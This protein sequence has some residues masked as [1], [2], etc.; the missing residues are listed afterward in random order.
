MADAL[1][2]ELLPLFNP[3]PPLPYLPPP[4]SRPPTRIT[5]VGDFFNEF[6]DESLNSSPFSVRETT[7]ERKKRIMEAR[8]KQN[9][10]RIAREL[11]EWNPKED[12]YITGDPRRTIIVANLS[13]KT[14]EAGLR[15]EF[16]QYGQV[17]KL[18]LVTKPDGTPTGRAFI[19]YAD[20]RSFDEAL[21]RGH[22]RYLDGRR[23]I[24][25]YERGRTSDS[26]RPRRLG[27]GKG[28]SRIA[29]D[30]VS[31]AVFGPP[32]H[33]TVIQPARPPF[34]SD[35]GGR[36]FGGD[37][38][39]DNRDGNRWD[40]RREGGYQGFGRDNR[41]EYGRDNRDGNRWDNRREGGDRGFGRDDRSYT[42]RYVP[43]RR[44]SRER[45]PDANHDYRQRRNYD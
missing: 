32:V 24:V 11:K 35:G 31:D 10:E 41:R 25:D 13:Y 39:R 20:T 19:E 27:G 17:N 38:R 30:L 8:K 23:I 12:P 29:H 40:N 4:P 22:G 36:R 6:E 9:E 16:E 43:Q 28:D 44:R 14:T 34:R 7:F 33:T 2:T 1:T 26:W 15:R 5:P 37:F 45:S 21:R 18:R 42:E 3:N